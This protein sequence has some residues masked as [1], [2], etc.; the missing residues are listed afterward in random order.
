MIRKNFVKTLS[1]VA[2]ATVLL[3]A[4]P[5]D[6]VILREGKTYVVNTSSL[7]KSIKGYLGTTP[8]KIY[9]TDNKIDKIESLPNQETPKYFAK[10]KKQLLDKWN[11]MTV[12]KAMKAQVDGVTGATLSSD[13][14]KK[15]VVK[16][17]E[18]YK[19]NKK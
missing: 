14:V 13:A 19:K 3:S 17:L 8:L 18:Y 11:G 4:M 10:V 9:I 12:S 1:L 5:G 7:T 16:G 15:N 2:C 6:E